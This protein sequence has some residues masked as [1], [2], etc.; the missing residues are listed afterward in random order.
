MAIRQWLR[1][2]IGGDDGMQE[3]LNEAKR[4]RETL[5]QTIDSVVMINEHNNVVFYNDAAAKLWGYSPEEVLGQNVKMLVPKAIQGNHD[6]LVNA[7]RRTGQNK[8]VGTH[9]EVEAVNKSGDTFWASLSLS[10]VDIEGKLYYTAFVRDITVQKNEQAF[11]EQT[12]EQAIDAV[13]TIDDD[14]IVRLFNKTAEKI[15]G[16]DRSEVIGRNVKMLVP[17]SLQGQHDDL[18]NA[19]R[20]TGVD[21][22]VGTSREIEV[23]TKTGETL[24]CSLALSRVKMGDKIHYTAFVRDISAE[25]KQREFINQTLEQAIDAVVAIDNHNCVT[26]FNKAAETLWGYTR[27]EVLGKNV[28][29]LVPVDIQSQHDHLIHQNRETGIDKIVGKSREVPIYRKDGSMRYGNLALSRINLNGEKHYTSFV[30]DVTEEVRRRK[31]FETLSLVANKTDNS[32]VI[33][34]AEGKI[35]YVNP[36]FTKLTGYVLEQCRG[37]A[38]GS[39]LQGPDTSEET[40]RNIRAKLDAR[41]AF[42]DEILNYDANGNSYWIS[43]AI[44]PVL[45]E[46]GELEKFISIQANITDTKLKSLEYNYRLEAIGRANAE[47]EFDLKGELNNCNDNFIAVLAES[48]NLAMN[49][50]S[51][52]KMLAS[53]DYQ[54][55]WQK[56]QAGEFA[57]GEFKLKVKGNLEH[58]VSGSFNPIFDSSGSVTKFVFYGTDVTVRKQAISVVSNQIQALAAGD[59]TATVEGEFGEELN[60]LRDAFNEST[61]KLNTL[62]LSIRTAANTVASGSEEIAKGNEDLHQRV[63]SQAANL[64]QT[65]S[66]MEEMTASAKN[67]AEYAQQAND[68][69]KEAGK[70]ATTG[71][72]VVSRAVEAMQ[73]I[74]D[75]SKKISDIITVIDEIAF[76]T[77][78]LALNAAVEAARA[79]EQGKGFAVVAAEVRNLAQRS[80][81]AAKEIGSLIHDTVGKV[82][83]G[84]THVNQSGDTLDKIAETVLDVSNMVAQINDA[85]TAQLEGISEANAAVASMDAMTQ[86]NAA[87]VEEANAASQEMRESS[88]SMVRDLSVFKVH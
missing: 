66:T 82:N 44:N 54:D 80:A 10:K 79:G 76:Q 6:E 50:Y 15:W 9:R 52:S 63:E 55:I 78:L 14:N 26:I 28:K 35:E 29:M 57:A 47:A 17:Q 33:T 71:R 48:D 74:T 4:L 30:R 36:G 46:D 51:L 37:K 85:S 20:R 72:Q 77:N 59:V 81:S 3:A 73:E 19:N 84:T 83:E 34:D 70:T 41:E 16:Y 49:Q 64:Q 8:I 56:L 42:Y 88:E 53:E 11:I 39:L 60:I 18:V 24:W 23:P 25:R 22:I 5:A 1:A 27:D 61:R 43:L 32:V 13:I 65:A 75:A 86:Q 67:N 12:L 7:N 40:R 2:W 45:N 68:K 62:L 69:S 87:L 58:W 21:K 31:E 38:P